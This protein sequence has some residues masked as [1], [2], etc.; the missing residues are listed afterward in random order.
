MHVYKIRELKKLC[1]A[2]FLLCCSFFF[3][4]HICSISNNS[5]THQ[6]SFS[7]VC[8]FQKTRKKY[9]FCLYKSLTENNPTFF[10]QSLVKRKRSKCSDVLTARGD[11]C[12]LKMMTM[13]RGLIFDFFPCRRKLLARCDGNTCVRMQCCMKKKVV[14]RT[15]KISKNA[16][17][18]LFSLVTVLVVEVVV[19]TRVIKLKTKS[20]YQSNHTK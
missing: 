11:V 12:S 13:R 8:F 7:L 5:S 15:L 20:R 19:T 9:I 6:Q 1:A 17:G 16:A 4:F 14:R 18:S 2:F 3:L 10:T